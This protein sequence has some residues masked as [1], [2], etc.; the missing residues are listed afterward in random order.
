MQLWSLARL[1]DPDMRNVCQMGLGYS[2]GVPAKSKAR[3]SL[4]TSNVPFVAIAR[5][6]VSGVFNEIRLHASGRAKQSSH[7]QTQTDKNKSALAM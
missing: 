7:L 1:R 3:S 6:A 4:E 5:R 2:D